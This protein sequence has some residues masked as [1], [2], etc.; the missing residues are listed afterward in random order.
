M[1]LIRS[2]PSFL[3]VFNPSCRSKYRR[4]GLTW[5]YSDFGLPTKAAA[6]ALLATARDACGLPDLVH[7][8][9]IRQGPT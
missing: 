8:Q 6:A 3:I 2:N 1:I 9:G 4:L 7:L 5:E